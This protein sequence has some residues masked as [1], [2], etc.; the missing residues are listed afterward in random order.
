M[1]AISNCRITFR[2]FIDYSK[3]YN[4]FENSEFNEERKQ[5]LAEA[6]FFYAGRKD[7]VL[8]YYCG[9]GLESW[10]E[11]DIA[12]EEHGKWFSKCPFVILSKG[13]R[14][15]EMCCGRLDK[16][17]YSQIT[18]ENSVSNTE[19]ITCVVCLTNERNIVCLP[20]KHCCMCTSC[21]LCIDACAICRC[22][23]H[24]FM[25]IYLF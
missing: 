16:T 9:G 13:P 23:I 11:N 8:C 14:F 25:D 12:W 21:A 20:C 18:S 5:E 7:S 1:A 3:R 4:T 10:K 22:P 24:S 15:I 2:D 17:K 19:S 6:G